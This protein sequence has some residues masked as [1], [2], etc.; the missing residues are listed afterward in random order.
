MVNTTFD[1]NNKEFPVDPNKEK[2]IPVSIENDPPGSGI[3]S[4]FYMLPEDML[5]TLGIRLPQ[6]TLRVKTQQDLIDGINATLETAEGQKLT[7]YKDAETD[8]ND[9]PIVQTIGY[10]VGKS[11]SLFLRSAAESIHQF[12]DNT[13]QKF[14]ANALST[15]PVAD[16]TIEYNSRIFDDTF[17]T[18]PPPP[19]APGLNTLF[20]LVGLSAAKVIIESNSRIIGWKSLGVI[21][22]FNTFSLSRM[23][24]INNSDGIISKNVNLAL[25]EITCFTTGLDVDTERTMFTLFA[26]APKIANLSLSQ[27]SMNAGENIIWLDPA[28]PDNSLYEITDVFKSPSTVNLL[29][30]TMA[31]QSYTEVVNSGGFALFTAI[32]HGLVDQDLKLVTSTNSNYADKITTITVPDSDHFLTDIV[33]DTDATGTF[34]NNRIEDVTN[35]AGEAQF[36]ALDHDIV[37]GTV[38]SVNTEN[39]V[40]SGF[41]TSVFESAFRVELPDGTIAPF[42]TSAGPEKGYWT[43]NSLGVSPDGPALKSDPKLILQNNQD[44]PDT[45]NQAELIQNPAIDPFSTDSVLDSW[46]DLH[47]N[48]AIADDF[49]EDPNT[50]N[51][52]S[53][54]ADGFILYL[55]KK[56]KTFKVSY[57][58]IPIAGS[59]TSQD[60]EF[61]VAL[62]ATAIPIDKT[63]R[64]ISAN[65]SNTTAVNYL[66]GLI[67][68][69]PDDKINIVKKNTTNS[70]FTNIKEYLVTLTEA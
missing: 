67:T 63:I 29:K 12:Y 37:A 32:G 21:S 7:I 27:F 18:T 49:I 42:T 69:N 70:V 28:S 23:G 5:Q 1:K 50:E 19:F 41:A 30:S 15:D 6:N 47:R 31:P 68:L 22:G 61:A 24:L 66:G 39:Y 59:G 4:D 26:T 36:E 55:G 13:G 53:T 2:R 16:V 17:D 52:S 58:L 25:R 46:E 43:T 38:I 35:I 34:I 60:L 57:S 44:V 11:S 64:T 40:L 51:F 33:F 3:F 8:E 10:K 45:M 65:N 62:N 56:T 20:D 9:D 54:D 14:L 48:P